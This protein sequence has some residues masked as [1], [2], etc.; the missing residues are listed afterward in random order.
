MSKRHFKKWAIKYNLK[1]IYYPN[2]LVY[3]LDL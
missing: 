1:I 2:G 3:H